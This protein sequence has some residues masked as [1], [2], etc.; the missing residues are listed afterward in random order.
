MDTSGIAEETP[1]RRSKRRHA[2]PLTRPPSYPRGRTRPYSVRVS[3]TEKSQES[4]TPWAAYLSQAMEVRELSAAE[5]ATRAGIGRATVYRWLKGESRNITMDSI[6]SIARALEE[7]PEVVMRAAGTTVDERRGELAAVRRQIEALHGHIA[8]VDADV[9]AGKISST[10][11]KSIT[12]PMLENLREAEHEEAALIQQAA[13]RE[14]GRIGVD[15]LWER[16]ERM[17]ELVTS[18]SEELEALRHQRN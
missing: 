13:Q 3:D 18:M 5:L 8:S 14:S 16:V 7:E 12:E 10:M 9:K 6:H 2:G 11:A 17:Q 15:V 1:R 4:Q